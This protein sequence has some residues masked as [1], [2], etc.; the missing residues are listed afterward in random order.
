MNYGSLV[1]ETT[2]YQW[3]LIDSP[4]KELEMRKGLPCY[5]P[6]MRT[7]RDDWTLNNYA[8]IK[9]A[10]LQYSDIFALRKQII[11]EF[12]QNKQETSDNYR[13]FQY[14]PAT[15]QRARN[16]QWIFRSDVND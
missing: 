4:H 8:Y 9:G 6:V 12:K 11:Y 1:R 5:D 3:Q 15:E 16:I 14:K 10:L 2:S 13:G 7:V